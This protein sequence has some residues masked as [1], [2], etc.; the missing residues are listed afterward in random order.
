MK[1]ILVLALAA[2]ISLS[3]CMP[4]NKQTAGG[5]TGAVV[6]GLAGSQFGKGRG[7]LVATGL[8]TLLGAWAGSEVGASLDKADQGY[9][10]Q[11]TERALE[12][13]QT[14]SEVRWSNPD[15]GNSGY[16]TPT[17]TWQDQANGEY[18]REFTQ[19]INVGGKKQSGV[20]VACRQPDGSWRIKG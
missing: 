2:S 7:Q 10:Q 1:K 11:S 13:A 4:A 18:C 14:G 20:G 3:A 19:N 12:T 5:L 8:G 9:L 15:S 16:I 6:G 17:R